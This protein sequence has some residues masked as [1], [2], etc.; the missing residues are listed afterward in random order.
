V[1]DDKKNTECQFN[2][3]ALEVDELT[4]VKLLSTLKPDVFYAVLRTLETGMHC[5]CTKIHPRKYWLQQVHNYKLAET[6]RK[7]KSLKT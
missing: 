1:T 3:C 2:A 5:I 4:F 7:I 6:A